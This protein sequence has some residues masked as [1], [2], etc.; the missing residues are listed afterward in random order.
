MEA[1]ILTKL[2]TVTVKPADASPMHLGLM[3][4]PPSESRHLNVV[5][6]VS[7]AYAL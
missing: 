5:V 7:Y 6:H 1:E 3:Q 4:P 2:K